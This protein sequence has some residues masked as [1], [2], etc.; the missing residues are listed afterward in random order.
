M[1]AL[2]SILLS[3]LVICLVCTTSLVVAIA[4]YS[5]QQAKKTCEH[6]NTIPVESVD[7]EIVAYICKDCDAGL[8]SDDFNPLK[9]EFEE[10]AKKGNQ[11]IIVGGETTITHIGP[12]EIDLDIAV[13]RT[14]I[15]N[16]KASFTWMGQ[17][18][19]VEPDNTK[20]SGRKI[21]YNLLLPGKDWTG[22]R[23][24]HSKTEPQFSKAGDIWFHD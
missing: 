1:E 23:R 18:I 22:D 19:N 3:P 13:P 11:T 4:S 8:F 2:L 14:V 21:G 20:V 24:F 9:R 15:G 6:K 12:R 17:T 7:G 16:Q 10:W 5:R